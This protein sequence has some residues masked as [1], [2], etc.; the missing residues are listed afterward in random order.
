[1]LEAKQTITMFDLLYDI[2]H[3]T[4]GQLKDPGKTDL[5]TTF[6]LYINNLDRCN[7]KIEQFKR[8]IL[9]DCEDV[10]QFAWMVK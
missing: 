8:A 3:T 10:C 1:M 2:L 6:S 7:S 5:E 4:I 9:A